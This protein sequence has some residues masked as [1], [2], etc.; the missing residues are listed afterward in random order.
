MRKGQLALEYL[1]LI[2][3]LTAGIIAMACYI[4][5][6]FQG[7]IRGLANQLGEQYSP[8][9]TVTGIGERKSVHTD[10]QDTTTS[11]SN[12]VD[13]TF[14]LTNKSTN[15]STGPMSGDWWP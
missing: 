8:G 3:L 13:N 12:N 11:T 5:R 2:G 9:N 15:E 7:N 10:S 1:I 4:K 6:G 14:E